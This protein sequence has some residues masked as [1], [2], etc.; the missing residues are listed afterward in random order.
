[1]KKAGNYHADTMHSF[2]DER[3]LEI[4]KSPDAV[5]HST[6]GSG[7]LI[8]R[9]G[10]DIVVTE[11]GGAGA[12][13]AITAYGPSGIRG[14]SGARALGGLPTDPGGPVTHADVV[15]GRIP[16][17]SGYMAPAVQIR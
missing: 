4:L 14:D 9:Q 7:R 3:V 17:K 8:F 5:Y 15:E 6:A 12:G 13:N 2:S 11:G 16:A 1:M 10:D